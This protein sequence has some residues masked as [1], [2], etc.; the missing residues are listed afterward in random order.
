MQATCV[1]RCDRCGGSGIIPRFMHRWNGRCLKCKGA[2]KV[3]KSL[4]AARRKPLGSKATSKRE[5]PPCL[6]LVA[7]GGYSL[8]CAPHPSDKATLNG[9]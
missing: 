2:G 7:M 5:V 8:C 9:G 3:S 1:V 4:L 6:A